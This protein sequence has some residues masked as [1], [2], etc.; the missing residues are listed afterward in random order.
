MLA[1]YFTYENAIM[2]LPWVLNSISLTAAYC[3]ANSKVVVGR[4]VA[5]CGAIGWASYGLIIDELSFFFANLFF[6]Y[7]YGSAVYKFNRK[8]DQYKVDLAQSEKENAQ[9]RA[10]LAMYESNANR[11]LSRKQ[12]S[13]LKLVSRARTD[14]DELEKAAHLH[15]AP[16][17]LIPV[18]QIAITEEAKPSCPISADDDAKSA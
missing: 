15:L 10:K 8:R 7:I 1:T 13:I 12:K 2:A 4:I 3:L 16:L 18:E 17:Q 5:L 11:E 14:L 9:L 6:I